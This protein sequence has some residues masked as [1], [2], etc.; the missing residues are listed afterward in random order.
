MDSYEGE[1]QEGLIL[2]SDEGEGHC[3]VEGKESIL[4]E[5]R[6]SKVIICSGSEESISSNPPSS[7]EEPNMKA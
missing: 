4:S 1:G 6:T 7:D 2:D 5:K 3:H